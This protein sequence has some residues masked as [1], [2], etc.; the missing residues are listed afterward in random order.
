VPVAALLAPWLIDHVTRVTA[1]L[2]LAVPR[3]SIGEVAV[4]NVALLVGLVIVT[5]GRL[6]SGL[7]AAYP[8]PTSRKSE[9]RKTH[10]DAAKRAMRVFNLRSPAFRD[11]NR[12]AGEVNEQAV[13][14]SAL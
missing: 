1:T 8:G 4:V 9:P 13:N 5:V 12:G 3:M 10:H 2:S 14:I 11:S 6:V 7:G